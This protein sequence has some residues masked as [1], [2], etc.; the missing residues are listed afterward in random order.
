MPKTIN[1]TFD[2]WP[3]QTEEGMTILQAAQKAGMVCATRY[4][5]L[6]KPATVASSADS[7]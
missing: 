3:V 1:M 7:R 2:G 6:R 4:D 5:Y